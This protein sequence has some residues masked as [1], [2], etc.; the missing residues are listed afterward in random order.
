M[1]SAFVRA[2]LAAVIG[3]LALAGCG[4]DV[5]ES[6][7]SNDVALAKVRDFDITTLASGELAAKDSVEI[8]SKVYRQTT[9]FSIVPEGSR[10]KKGDL[11]VS[12][13]SDE[14][15]R[16]LQEEETTLSQ[17]Q[18]DLD[19]AE[20]NFSITKSDNEAAL[21]KSKLDVK[22]AQIALNQWRDGDDPKKIAELES[23]IE[24][25]QKDFERQDNKV[26]NSINL[27][28][29]DFLSD[30][31]LEL[32][33]IQ[34]LKARAALDNA[35]RELKVYKNYQRIQEE[36]KLIGDLASA[37]QELDRVEQQNGINLKRAESEVTRRKARLLDQQKDVEEERA[38]LAACEMYAPTDG[39][40]VY[41]TTA[42]GRDSYRSQNEGPLDVGSA[43][44]PN[45]LLV[46][47][48]DT[49][50]MMAN[51]KVHE[52]LAGR[53][54]QGQEV[55]VKVGAAGGAQLTGEVAS[56]GVLAEGGGW[57]DPNR[58][59]YTVRVRLDGSAFDEQLKP[60]MRCEAE[61]VL[62]EAEGSLTIPVQ[63]VFAE[64]QVR[65]V[66]TPEGAKYVRK[67]IKMG[68]RSDLWAE[69]A[70]GID[71][72]TPVL[73]R[74]P[75]PGEILPREWDIAE[76]EAAGYTIDEEGRPVVKRAARPRRSAR[77]DEAKTDA[78]T[79]K[80]GV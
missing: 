68:R 55:R 13:A 53:V 33:R 59:E 9:I 12:L 1:T 32:D 56:I 69:I 40:V 76:L 34:L 51:V 49:S 45:D 78:E 28:A 5:A 52:S 2:G 54:R 8:R 30:D 73:I 65:Y 67:P 25:N 42:S 74:E 71:P 62:G 10:V 6:G 75:T 61:I 17:Y 48:P 38:Q 20:A 24:Q 16:S 58:R 19:A 36:E 57:R 26:E 7:Q 39:L 37:Q 35:V 18:L 43:V 31:E 80:T 46:V 72:E 70:A 47:L 44:R 4:G 14:I 21:A 66:Y 15:E 60:S 79:T 27:H 64:G 11:L 22:L 50:E 63:A 41:G 3:G 29:Q 77:A 23:T